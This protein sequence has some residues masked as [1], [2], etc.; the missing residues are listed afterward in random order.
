MHCLPSVRDQNE[1]S[2]AFLY[3]CSLGLY[4]GLQ[5]NALRNLHQR[6]LARSSHQSFRHTV[7]LPTRQSCRFSHNSR[8]H[9]SHSRTWS[10]RSFGRFDSRTKYFGI[11]LATSVHRL[12][13]VDVIMG[14]NPAVNVIPVTAFT[15]TLHEKSVR[16]SSTLRKSVHRHGYKRHILHSH[17]NTTERDFLSVLCWLG[18]L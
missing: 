2:K 12:Q 1:W 11:E 6:P 13:I 14:H 3:L 15:C 9:R 8:C 5:H 16:T 10:A 18:L 17:Y 7:L 4:V